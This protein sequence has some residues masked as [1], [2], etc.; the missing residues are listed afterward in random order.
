MT[1]LDYI[2]LMMRVN[3]KKNF[4]HW[5]KLSCTFLPSNPDSCGLWC[6]K[7]KPHGINRRKMVNEKLVEHLPWGKIQSLGR[8]SEENLKVEN[9]LDMFF[10]C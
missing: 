2:L 5:Q 4:K 9:K 6:S 1:N 10:F 3:A 7:I 8:R